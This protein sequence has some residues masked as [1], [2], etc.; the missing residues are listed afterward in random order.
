MSIKILQLCLVLVSTFKEF[1]EFSLCGAAQLLK[2]RC[3]AIVEIAVTN[4]TLVKTNISTVTFAP[5]KTTK[6]TG[7]KLCDLKMPI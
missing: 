2:L 7:T 3:S 1:V 4:K 6:T 5:I